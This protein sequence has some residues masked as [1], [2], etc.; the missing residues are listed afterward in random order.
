MRAQLSCLVLCLCVAF[1]H[2]QSYLHRYAN[3]S[4]DQY[5]TAIT[6]LSGDRVV[7]GG[8]AF[9][10]SDKAVVVMLDGQGSVLWNRLYDG[11][12]AGAWSANGFAETSDGN[13]FTLFSSITAFSRITR[14]ASLS[15]QNG[16]VL[17]V[18]Q[19][20]T[21]DRPALYLDIRRTSDGFILAGTVDDVDQKSCFSLLKTDL[22][23][24]IL[25]QRSVRDSNL[26]CNLSCATVADD[27]SFWALGQTQVDNFSTATVTLLH[28]APDGTWL[29][30]YHLLPQ[31]AGRKVSLY[32]IDYQPGTGP[33]VGLLY[34]FDGPSSVQPAVVQLNT[35]GEVVWAREVS[36]PASE[37]Q[38]PVVRRLSDGNL[39][40]GCGS[41]GAPNLGVLVKLSPDGE[42]LWARDFTAQ[43]GVEALLAMEIDDA[44][45]AYGAGIVFAP[46]PALE[47]KGVVLRT[48]DARFDT[49]SC[50]SRSVNWVTT[51]I[52]FATTPID[53]QPGYEMQPQTISLAQVNGT[54][55]RQ[56]VC[57]SD[58]EPSLVVS[59][60][61]V[62]PG[63]CVVLTPGTPSGPTYT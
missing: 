44:D 48:D 8:G 29:S 40:V 42:A 18:Q 24:N 1:A 63:Q 39:L 53:L 14:L 57:Q 7:T 46:L 15:D 22:Q 59:D 5:F 6:P 11:S 28:F 31:A 12:P 60:S 16:Q 10:V 33:V 34:F 13:L 4:D 23:G 32:S 19:T 49:A 25:W 54:T 27:G 56:D 51:P 62:C 47:R 43:D 9:T 20:G 21:V 36:T 2:G 26:E 58:F 38:L 35:E 52:P 17:S 55:T 61:V 3:A 37:Y 45:N 50:C 41:G 30:A